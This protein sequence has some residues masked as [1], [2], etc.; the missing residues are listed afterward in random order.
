MA[1]TC[2][3]LSLSTAGLVIGILNLTTLIIL[4]F[5]L[6]MDMQFGMVIVGK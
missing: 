2:C 5:Y 4:M 1:K 3:C 6:I